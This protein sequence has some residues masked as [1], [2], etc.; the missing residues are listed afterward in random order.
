MIDILSLDKQELQQWLQT[1]SQPKYRAG[2]I[3]SR[4]HQ[5]A[6]FDGMTNIPLSLRQYLK[7]NAIIKTPTPIRKLTSRDGTVKYLMKLYDGEVVES[8]LMR[9]NHGNSVCISSQVGCRMGC[10]F[11]ASTLKGLKRSLAP[12][13]L[14][15]QVLAIQKDSG[16]R[17]SNIV[18]MG[19]GEPLDNYDATV[20][21]LHLVSCPDGLNIGS[22]HIS[23]STC[24]IVP[25]IYELAQH[26]FGITLS[27]S[28]HAVSDEARGEIMPI[29]K[30]YNIEKLLT[31]CRDYFSHT[32][33]RISFEYTLISGVNDSE[34]DAKRLAHILRKYLGSMPIHVN[35]IPVNEVKERGFKKSTEANV[36]RFCDRLN[37]CTVVATVRRSLGSDIDASCGQLRNSYTEEEN[38][39]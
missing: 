22:R 27:I 34:D 10:K 4:L 31:A 38:R 19:I 32:G 39:T 25:K 24:G 5:G 30:K 29:N 37:S 3:F 36:K 16:Q 1:L 11:C 2:Q 17:V 18:M 15:G 8:V 26:D 20:K 23:V 6:D 33:R 7:E 9:Y 12:S 13:E 35:L 14:L 28:L 21:F